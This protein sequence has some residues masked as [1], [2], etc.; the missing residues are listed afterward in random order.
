MWRRTGWN[1]YLLNFHVWWILS[2]LALGHLD[3]K[4]FFCCW[5]STLL[6]PII[7]EMS[8]DL[9]KMS[10]KHREHQSWCSSPC[11]RKLLRWI[12]DIGCLSDLCILK[13]MTGQINPVEP[14]SSSLGASSFCVFHYNFGHFYIVFCVLF[15][16]ALRLSSALS[17]HIRM[18]RTCPQRSDFL[19]PVCR[20][21]PVLQQVK[22]EGVSLGFLW[23]WQLTCLSTVAILTRSFV[24]LA[25]FCLH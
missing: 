9:R 22:H 3:K 23:C 11:Q 6:P 5:E 14:M 16:P 20:L 25:L 7:K 2:R 24:S 4:M 13:C 19:S 1:C 18:R 12:F 21:L 8:E 10:L 17:S 15:P